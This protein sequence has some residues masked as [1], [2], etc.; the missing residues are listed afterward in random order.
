MFMFLL[1]IKSATY[2]VNKKSSVIK[3]KCESR[4]GFFKKT[5]PIKF[6]EKWTFLTPLMRTCTCA[7]QGVR[8]VHFSENLTCFVFLKYPLCDSQFK[9][10]PR[11]NCSFKNGMERLWGQFIPIIPKR[12]CWHC[13]KN[14]V[15]HEGF[16]Q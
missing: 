10:R 16:L 2:F 8:N 7:Y 12:F 11:K 14:E 13:T 15:F 6:P 3:Q 5:K 9:N 1:K 4:N